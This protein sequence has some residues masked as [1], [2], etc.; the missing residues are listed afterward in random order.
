MDLLAWVTDENDVAHKTLIDFKTGKAIYA[1]AYMQTA[2]YRHAI[3]EMGLDAVE[4][5]MIVRLPKVE[6]DPEFE[7]VP[8]PDMDG[9]FLAFLHAL[10][11]WRWQQ[12]R[13]AEYKAKIE[14][15]KEI[16]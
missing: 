15:L 3:E 1:E 10:G 12:V 6:S 5:G 9:N 7:A 2:A 16:A 13:E 4:Q 14:S 11:L 8:V